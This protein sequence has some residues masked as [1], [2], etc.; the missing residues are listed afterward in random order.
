LGIT[1]VGQT[2]MKPRLRIASVAYS[3]R[4]DNANALND[5]RIVSGFVA[6]SGVETGS[7]FSS[8]RIDTG[9]YR[10]TFNDEFSSAPDVIASGKSSGDNWIYVA[11]SAKLINYP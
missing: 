1:V 3:L 2:E 11:S 4:A 9:K 10:I 7:E 5:S 6:S 8:Q